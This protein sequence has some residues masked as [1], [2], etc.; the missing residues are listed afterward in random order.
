M[1]GR[2]KGVEEAKAVAMELACRLGRMTQREVGA[3]YGGVSSQAVSLARKRVRRLLSS[4]AIERLVVS[5]QK[6][7]RGKS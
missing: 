2:R 6:G 7:A 3:R 4:D 1:S 5:V